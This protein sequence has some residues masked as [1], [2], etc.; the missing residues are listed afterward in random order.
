[1]SWSWRR[2][3][4]ARVDHEDHRVGFG[5]RLLASAWPSREMPSRLSGS[6]PPVS[7]TMNSCPPGARRRSGGRAS[8]RR[9]RPRSR[10]ASCVRRLNRVDLPT[11]GPADQGDDGLHVPTPGRPHRRPVRGPLAGE[12]PRSRRA[13]G[14]LIGRDANR[15]PLRVTTSTAPQRPA[16]HD[17]GAV[18]GAARSA[19]PSSRDS[20]CTVPS[21][22]P[23]DA[24]PR[25]TTSGALERAV[26]AACPASRRRRRSTSPGGDAAVGV[27]ARRR[28]SVVAAQAVGADR[29]LALQSSVPRSASTQRHRRLER[30]RADHVADAQPRADEVGQALDLVGAA[31]RA[32]GTSQRDVP[33]SGSTPDQRGPCPATSVSLHGREH[34]GLRTGSAD[35]RGAAA[36]SC[37]RRARRR[38]CTRGRRRTTNTRSP[39]TSGAVVTRDVERLRQLTCAGLEARPVRRRA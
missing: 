30:A 3:A 34:A 39:A 10:R 27:G 37:G 22:S 36:Q 32:T 5:H 6:K 9:S 28:S 25:P 8:G 15:P 17:R 7:M 16:R 26:Q 20:K 18:G 4:R 38:R 33:L 35:R 2:Q 11:F 23:N 14:S 24:P 29:R 1:M 19:A 12:Q 31:R 21:M 13:W